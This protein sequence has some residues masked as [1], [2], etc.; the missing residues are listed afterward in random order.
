ML[1]TYNANSSPYSVLW[2]CAI[3]LVLGGRPMILARS[4]MELVTTIVNKVF[5]ALN[6]DTKSSI[7][8]I[9]EVLDPFL[10]FIDLFFNWFKFCFR[11]K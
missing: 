4:K 1:F 5:Q 10:V 11:S 6:A 9:A 7:L 8:N 3:A 2:K